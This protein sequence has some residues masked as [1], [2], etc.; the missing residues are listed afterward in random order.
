MKW[1]LGI[2]AISTT[3]IAYGNVTITAS[4]IGIGIASC[5]AEMVLI[6]MRHASK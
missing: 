4:I 1:I 2:I 6:T 3:G 5:V